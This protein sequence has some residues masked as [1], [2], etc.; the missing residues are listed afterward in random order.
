MTTTHRGAPAD[1]SRS[2][3]AGPLRLPSIGLL[4]V[5]T[6]IAFEAMAVAAALPTAAR[7]LHGLAD[8]GWAFTGFLIANIVAMV[9]S[10]MMSDRVGPARPLLLGLVTFF[11]GLLIAGSAT[12]MV[13]LVAGRVVQGLGGGLLITAMYVV[14]GE[15]YS[16]ALRPKI[17]AAISSAWVLP[18]LIGPPVSGFVTQHLSW[19]W[20]FLGLAPLV[21]LGGVLIV[22]A[23]R[24]LRRRDPTTTA[25]ADPMRLP[26]AFAVAV[27]IVLLE[28]AGQHPRP[29]W[30]LLAPVGI[31]A[32]VWGL[33]GGASSLLPPGT[34]RVRRGVPTAV[35]FR[36]MLA[37]AIFGVESL[38]PL[39]LT[40]QHGF[41][42]TAA[43][44]PLLGSAL[45]WAAG[46]WWQGRDA[47]Q[48]RAALVRAGFA[49]VAL[50]A[51]VAAVASVPAFPALL[52]YPAWLIGG[53]GAGLAMS[54]IGVLLLD[55]TTDADR[56]RDSAALQLSDGVTSALTTGV[57]GVLVA[58]AARGTLRYTTAFVAI[59]LLMAALAL[60]G[61]LLA[62]R[63][64]R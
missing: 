5:V 4:I 23:L 27:G 9:A 33:V 36:G 19:R 45:G 57:G 50:G 41:G 37:G 6:L 51:V 8:Y 39:A 20:V 17:F 35:A 40:V 38:I 32:L 59:D 13:Q 21:A 22:P 63:A 56:G 14:I 11:A 28:Q 49:F 30:L 64:R 44:L 62:G 10:G 58:G 48:S 52:M 46:S 25:P 29:T 1:A 43:G 61:V 54:S 16:A 60:G 3:F 34:V 55:W 53:L 26:R 15:S 42:A 47:V 24:S 31:V 2:I 12:T 7:E 18:S